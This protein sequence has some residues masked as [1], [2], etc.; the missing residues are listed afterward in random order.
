M[1]QLRFGCQRF[2]RREPGCC[3]VA[4]AS[5]G[6]A[7][8]C[9]ESRFGSSANGSRTLLTEVWGW[10]LFHLLPFWLFR[11]TSS[12]GRVG[13]TELSERFDAFTR[14]H[15]GALHSAKARDVSCSCASDASGHRT[16]EQKARAACQEVRVGEVS[17]ARQCLTGACLAPK[18]EEPF[19]ELQAW[20]L[21]FQR[22]ELPPEVLEFEPETPVELDRRAFGILKD[23]RF[24]PILIFGHFLAPL[25]SRCFHPIMNF[26]H[27]WALLPSPLTFHNVKNHGSGGAEGE[28]G[29]IAGN[30]EQKKTKKTTHRGKPR[31]TET[32][33]QRKTLGAGQ[34]T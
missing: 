24:Y 18:C 15:R 29:G 14:G 1:E 25:F 31:Q 17:R 5:E 10:K 11:K 2:F 20:R 7:S 28:P 19:R 21:Q 12:R 34:T 9:H 8:I 26:G 16:P 22:R 32:K 30:E 4:H 3:R 27:F 13:K 6:E 33:Q 23:A